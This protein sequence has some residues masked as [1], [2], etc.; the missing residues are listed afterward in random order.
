M[1]NKVSAQGNHGRAYI[2][3]Y[4]CNDRVQWKVLPTK[5]NQDMEQ[6]GADAAREYLERTGSNN[7]WVIYEAMTAAAP[8]PPAHHLQKRPVTLP[9]CEAK[10]SSS[11]DWD[12]GYSDG[13]KACL[14]EVTKLG[15]LYINADSGEIEID[16]R[17][18]FEA[19]AIKKGWLV[20]QLK[21]RADGNYEDWGVNPEWQA[22]KARAALGQKP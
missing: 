10:L 7:L 17:A 3:E 13:W 15:P 12:Q 14:E 20:H 4:F 9:A 22:W 11:H 18:E 2:D 21:Q 1:T 16:E 8:K 19:Y 6:A 5:A